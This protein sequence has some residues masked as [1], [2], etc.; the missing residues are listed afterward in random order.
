MKS[1]VGSF[2]CEDLV[3]DFID[4]AVS[5]G[6]SASKLCAVGFRVH[7]ELKKH[8]A[9]FFSTSFFAS[10]VSSTRGLARRLVC[11][12]LESI[13][14]RDKNRS[15]A[16]LFAVAVADDDD[17]EEEEEEILA[18]SVP[19]TPKALRRS[20]TVGITVALSVTG[21]PKAVIRTGSLMLDL[22]VGAVRVMGRC[23]W[24]A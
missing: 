13:A 17:D 24:P 19:R 16:K 22:E 7:D 21:I 18:L 20:S 2:F 6:A 8:R 4:F 23:N 1:E 9:K 3:D 11:S 14:K 12:L 5:F 15:L 10:L